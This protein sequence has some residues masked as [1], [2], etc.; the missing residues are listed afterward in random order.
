MG[1]FFSVRV[2]V[3]HSGSLYMMSLAHLPFPSKIIF[4]NALP[5]LNHLCDFI[6]KF[7]FPFK[8][9]QKIILSFLY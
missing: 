9:D 8:L 1:D 2:T 3:Q 5:S 7:L 6:R 4:S